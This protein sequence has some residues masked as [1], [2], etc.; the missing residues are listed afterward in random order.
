[1][2]WHPAKSDSSNHSESA[3]HFE[4]HACSFE[5][6]YVWLQR[7][8]ASVG[9]FCSDPSILLEIGLSIV[10]SKNKS[11]STKHVLCK[12]EFTGD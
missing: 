1:M 4:K 9:S 8:W 7:D 12:M 6:N 10:S 5:I 2:Y 11:S 3:G